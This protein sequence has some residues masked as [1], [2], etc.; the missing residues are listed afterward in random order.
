M[1]KYRK[2]FINMQKFNNNTKITII[3][4]EP[5]ILLNKNLQAIARFMDKK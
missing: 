5:A 3:K 1:M 4:R 2:Y